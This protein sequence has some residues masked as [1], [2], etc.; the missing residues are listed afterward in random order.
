MTKEEYEMER[1]TKLAEMC[2][3]LRGYAETIGDSLIKFYSSPDHNQGSLEKA[4][5]NATLAGY[6]AEAMEDLLISLRR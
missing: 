3:Q 1:M 4:I 6:H 5:N 2:G